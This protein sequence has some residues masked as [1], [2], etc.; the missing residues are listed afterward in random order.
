MIGH[1]VHSPIESNRTTKVRF[2]ENSPPLDFVAVNWF[3]ALVVGIG[4]QDALR[5]Q[6][7]DSC[8][9]VL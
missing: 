4:R 9:K 3:A 6:P 2:I 5:L 8:F 7:S 1:R